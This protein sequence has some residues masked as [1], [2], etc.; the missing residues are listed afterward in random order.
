MPLI[1]ITIFQ[2]NLNEGLNFNVMKKLL[3]IK[4]DIMVFPEYINIDSNIKS[5]NEVQ[6]QSKVALDWLLK[7]N[8][9]Y[10]GIIIGGSL[11][12]KDEEGKLYNACP[13]IY[14]NEIIDWYYKKN[15]APYEK[16][17]LTA[18]KEPGIFILNN[19]R[20]GVL[21]GED[22]LDSSNIDELTKQN[23][24]LII[25]INKT[26]E[27]EDNN[28]E[29]ILLNYAKQNNQV[30]IKCDAVGT[31]FEKKL[32]GKSSLITPNGISWHVTPKEF[33]NQILKNLMVQMN[34]Y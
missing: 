17:I 24:K 27:K 3:N 22:F 9:T 18:G 10:K 33:E 8:N 31:L 20:F 4:S 32:I 5:I 23:I 2:K 21:I 30:F 7:L 13:I 6:D 1:N 34:S 26:F 14:N 12:K 16:K 15:L 25:I 29:E 11:I 28:H 19:I